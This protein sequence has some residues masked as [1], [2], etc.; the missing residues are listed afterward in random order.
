MIKT[1]LVF[2][3]IT[4]VS[5]AGAKCQPSQA[6]FKVTHAETITKIISHASEVDRRLT[7]Q[8]INTSDK[9]MIV[10]GNKVD[11]KLY[12]AG[13]L[14]KFDEVSG[15]WLYPTNSGKPLEWRKVSSIDKDSQV[16]KPGEA[17]EFWMLYGSAP[18][19]EGDKRLK[20]TARVSCREGKEPF[21]IRSEEFAVK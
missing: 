1:V 9:P 8:I 21:E 12:P 14:L 15:Q 13:Y 11:G 2:L 17:L 7:L 16:L 5:F 18:Y 4:D 6:S 3:L 19:M 10:Y 20:L